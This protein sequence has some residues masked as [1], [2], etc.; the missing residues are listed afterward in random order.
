M[1][2][3]V[4]LLAVFL[5]LV[6]SACASVQELRTQ[7]ISENQELFDSYPAEVR[8]KILRGEIEVGFT[9]DMVRMAW[10]PADEVFSRTMKHRRTTVWEYTRLRRY[11]DM[12]WLHVPMFYFD[13][14]GRRSIGFHTVW[15]D[16]SYHE[17]VPVARV[18]FVGERVTAFEERASE[19]LGVD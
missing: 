16:R 8:S 9:S 18:E 13:S 5:L 12:D 2:V 10:G 11:P 17:S 1:P 15:V 7:R 4:A 3:R 6:L 14:S 19:T